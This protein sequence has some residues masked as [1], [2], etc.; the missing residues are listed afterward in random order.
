MPVGLLDA[1]VDET[2]GFPPC[3]GWLL[4]RL[5]KPGDSG[6][7]PFV[8][9]RQSVYGWRLDRKGPMEH[10]PHLGGR[11]YESNAVGGRR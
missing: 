2:L 6:F 8:D 7:T 4:T 9:E 10:Q 3:G 1:V 5:K 11:I